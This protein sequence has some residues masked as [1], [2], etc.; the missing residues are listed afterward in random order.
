MAMKAPPG[1]AA[2]NTSA[3]TPATIETQSVTPRI[4]NSAAKT[5]AHTSRLRIE[6]ADASIEHAFRVGDRE[7]P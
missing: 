5:A 2:D 1:T 3:A 6:R 4:T 7:P